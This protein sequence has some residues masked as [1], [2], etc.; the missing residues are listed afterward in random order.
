MKKCLMVACLDA[1]A[2]PGSQTATIEKAFT[3]KRIV[4]F[5]SSDHGLRE[6]RKK[7]LFGPQKT[8]IKQN[9]VSDSILP[10]QNCF[11]LLD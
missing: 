3:S 2:L 10:T 7:G 11:M 1:V 6:F 9:I 8:C 5:H 4:G